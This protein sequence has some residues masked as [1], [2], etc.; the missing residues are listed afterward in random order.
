M[1]V[2]HHLGKKTSGVNPERGYGRPGE[3]QVQR[4][5]G[6]DKDS[7]HQISSQHD[8][9]WIIHSKSEDSGIYYPTKKFELS[10]NF[11]KNATKWPKNGQNDQ[12][13]P[14]WPKYDPKWPKMAQNGPRM[15][16]N[17]PKWPE[18]DPKWPKITPN[19]P[20]I[21]PG[22]TDSFRDFFFTEKAIPQKNLNF[23]QISSKMPQNGPKMAKNDPTCPKWP[24]YDPKWP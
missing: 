24:K 15:T 17:D 16:Q 5:E 18:N 11:F 22:F 23:P 21:T 13:G 2:N 9:H 1:Q 12:N 6:W 3:D 8:N 19:G 4:I 10:A 14:K 20:K 7:H